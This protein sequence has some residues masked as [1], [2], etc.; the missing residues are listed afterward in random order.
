MNAVDPLAEVFTVPVVK[1]LAGPRSYQRGVAYSREGR[2][3]A[4]LGT[5]SRLEV[6]VYGTM[7]YVVE[8]GLEEGEPR[9]SC[10]CPAAEDGSF[11]KHCVAVALTLDPD[12]P[13]DPPCSPAP[14]SPPAPAADSEFADAVQRLRARRASDGR[15][16]HA[17]GPTEV[18]RE[19][20]DFVQRLPRDRLASIV[21]E[22]AAAERRLRERL[23]AEVRADR[24]ED[25]DL[26][27]W[28][29]RIDEAFAPYGDFVS[30]RE[31]EGWAAG[32]EE[33]ID[34][35]E[36]LCDA[37]HPDAVILLVE[38][39]HG[40]AEEALTYVDGSD[41]WLWGIAE[42][43]VDVHLRACE[44]GCPDPA[45]LAGRLVEL[46]LNSE[47]G[48]F[49]RAAAVYADVLGAAG[50]AV[51]RERLES[52]R[53]RL[54]TAPDSPERELG[55]YGLQGAMAG[56]AI[57]TGDPDNLIE[58]YST[59]EQIAPDAALEIAR[60]LEDAGRAG[61]AIH[62]AERGLAESAY[63]FWPTRD[64][65][66]YLAARLRERGE[67]SAAVE[68]FWVAFRSDPALESYRC[69]LAE[70]GEGPGVAHGW[71]QRCV[72]ELRARVAGQEADGEASARRTGSPAA[73]VLVEIL[74]FEGLIDEAWSA[75]LS[76]GCGREMWMTL[77]R[78]REKINPLDAVDV[79][80]TEVL[81][82]IDRKKTSY[83]ESAVD[84]MDRIRRLAGTAGGPDRFGGL[85]G[86][87]RTE[88]RAKRN[89]KKL[90]DEK[91]W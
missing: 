37:G 77:A 47:L 41:G 19:L 44:D 2:V 57:A 15:G 42:R 26:G 80:E 69:L 79:Y 5:D 63:R 21:L 54:D 74:L 71:S 64:L 46:E 20:A 75:A 49:H 22:W 40:R 76:F 39:A 91:G 36:D 25:P 62:W 67:A 90:L 56:W 7:P 23:L 87:V 6:T 45:A 61:E 70:A 30:Y 78:A 18:H 50:L 59:G 82:L 35:L 16:P 65:R 31:A 43:L 89:L 58:V 51:Y 73:A 88:H 13:S 55:S 29:R 17:G 60:A 81:A 24:G 33:A 3:S 86:R 8:L 4:S 32:A 28:R 48:G 11:C 38:H 72:A 83:Y 27:E 10:T 52:H 12:E 1:G 9:W 53:K 66:E 85:L 84:L 68:L 14:G 34:A